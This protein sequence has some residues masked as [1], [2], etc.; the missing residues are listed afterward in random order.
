VTERVLSMNQSGSTPLPGLR[1]RGN[2]GALGRSVPF[3]GMS[4]HR[5]VRSEASEWVRH[6]TKQRRRPMWRLRPAP[7]VCDLNPHRDL[8]QQQYDR[9]S[10]R[11]FQSMRHG[12]HPHGC[13]RS[14]L[15][16]V[17]GPRRRRDS[18]HRAGMTH[19]HAVLTVTAARKTV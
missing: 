18:R 11:E 19:H 4:A 14:A 3:S 7:G 12:V 9:S 10:L 15:R 8:L 2:H 17:H 16:P 5:T 1:A 6:R 13:C